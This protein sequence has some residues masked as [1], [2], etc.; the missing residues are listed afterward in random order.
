MLHISYIT[1][2]LI[3]EKFHLRW[4]RYWITENPDGHQLVKHTTAKQ[5]GFELTR[6]IWTTLN[7]I[8]T[9]R[10]R[11][12]HMMFKW[13][14]RDSEPCDC[15]PESQTTSHII[16]HLREF[17]GT[18]CPLSEKRSSKVDGGIL[19]CSTLQLTKILNYLNIYSVLV[20]VFTINFLLLFI[21]IQ[22][23]Y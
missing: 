18:R 7:H 14:F 15:G 13:K 2:K 16:D 17:K 6:K 8:K 22:Y 3:Q 5:P 23:S 12:G 9:G 21:Y 10:G 1:R 11:S 4:E 20:I 19:C